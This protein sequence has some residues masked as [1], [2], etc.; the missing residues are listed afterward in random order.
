MQRKQ[1]QNK[2]YTVWGN[3]IGSFTDTEFQI[4]TLHFGKFFYHRKQFG[5]NFRFSE[6]NGI[7][8][9]ELRLR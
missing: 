6:N 4:W 2:H 3:F 8:E 1:A 9:C 7:I 5:I